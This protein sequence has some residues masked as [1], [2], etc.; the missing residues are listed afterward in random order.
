MRLAVGFSLLVLVGGTAEVLAAPATDRACSPNS[1]LVT[2]ERATQFLE[3]PDLL[4]NQYKEGQGGLA[5]EIRDFLTIRPETIEGIASLAKASSADQ[6]RAI[7]AGL[8]TAAS[9]CVLT[10]PAFAQQIQEVVLKTENPGLIQSFVSITG[11][12]PTE[13]I[14][15]ADPGGDTTAGGGEGTTTVQRAGTLVTP[16]TSL[17]NQ[18][19]GGGGVPTSTVASTTPTPIFNPAATQG[20]AL[21]FSVSPSQ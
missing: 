3:H 8:G 14:T 19:T 17:L 18:T 2:A 20:T 9:V 15:G 10:Q 21:F 7:G 6:S 5:S 4:L 13:A 12:I 16:E 11:D 1:N